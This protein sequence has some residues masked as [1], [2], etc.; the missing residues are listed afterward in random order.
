MHGEQPD[1]LSCRSN[2]MAGTQGRKGSTGALALEGQRTKTRM[3]AHTPGPA[4][5]LARGPAGVPKLKPEEEA[6]PCPADSQAWA[7]WGT[8]GWSEGAP[9]QDPVGAQLGPLNPNRKGKPPRAWWTPRPGPLRVWQARGRECQ[10]QGPV[11]AWGPA[12]AL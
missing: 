3:G 1:D 12:G 8:A 11:G 9:P 4:R 10:S 5:A 7:P 2:Q 6:F